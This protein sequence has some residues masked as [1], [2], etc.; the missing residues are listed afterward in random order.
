[1][2]NIQVTRAIV[3]PRNSTVTECIVRALDLVVVVVVVPCVEGVPAKDLPDR[4]AIFS[5]I[6][7]LSPLQCRGL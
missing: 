2:V 4:V 7:Q 1:M 3:A 6:I 5:F